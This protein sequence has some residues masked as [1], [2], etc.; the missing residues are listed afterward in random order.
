L[1]KKKKGENNMAVTWENYKNKIVAMSEEGLSSK[2]IAGILSKTEPE[3]TE[4]LDRSIRAALQRW[5]DDGGLDIK[6]KPA[7]VLLFDIETSPFLTY[8]WNRKP[9][10]L[11]EQMIIEEWYVINWAAKWL[12][13]DE[14]ITGVVT[15]E[16]SKNK[17]DRRIVEKLW[18]LLDEADIVI[19]H[20]GDM[21]DIKMM[22]GRF[23]K[24]NLNLPMPYKT[25]DTKKAAGKRMRLP[26]LNL[27]YIARYMGLETKHTTN[28]QLWVDCMAGDPEA[29]EKM[30][31]Y[32]QQ[33]V[34]ILED[35]YLKLRP[36]IQ[37]HP[38]LGLF[39]ESD[40]KACPACASTKLKK[41]GTYQTTVNLY[42]AYRCQDCGSI[43]RSRHAHKLNKD[44]IT[45]SVP[46]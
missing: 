16:E 28:F 12:F 31:K 42:D 30:D 27:N 26:A 5:R 9:S 24:Y 23:F 45:S 13:E 10:Y 43:T 38:N 29:L 6:K 15:P 11:P 21:F 35:V 41:E 22:N 4:D 7:K 36:Y 20:Y 44:G 2:E 14:T 19:A 3:I 34:K 1:K 17:D 37:P 25:I 18:Y 33:D 32:C 40:A 46:R 39:I 8:N